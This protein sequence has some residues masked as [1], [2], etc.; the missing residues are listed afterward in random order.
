MPLMGYSESAEK[1]D[2]KHNGEITW[3]KKKVKIFAP[4]VRG[5]EEAVLRSH[6]GLQ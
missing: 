3:C 4:S 6:H 5:N 1:V 2:T